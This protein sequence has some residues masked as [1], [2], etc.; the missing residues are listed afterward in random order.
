MLK[1]RDY[2]EEAIFHMINSPNERMVVCL[3]TGAGKTVVFSTYAA[4]MVASGQ[5]V[6][7][8]VNRRE[9]LTQTQNALKKMGI[10]AG[11]ISSK[12]KNFPLSKCYVMMVETIARRKAHLEA[13]KQRCSVLIVDECHIG[14]F[15]KILDGFQ[16]VIGFSATPMVTQ[17]KTPL[18]ADYHN[19]Y[20]PVQVSD[21]IKAG[22]LTNANTYAPKN[23]VSSKN[24]KVKRST[25][26]FD[27]RQMGDLLSQ[28]KYLHYAVS[29]AKKYAENKRSIVYNANIEH[30]LAVTHAMKSAGLNAYHVD[31]TTPDYERKQILMNL[32]EQPDAIVNNVGILTFGFDCPEVETIIL[33]RATT[34]LP[35]YLQMC[36]RGSRLSSKITKDSFTIVDLCGNYALHGQWQDDRDWDTLFHKKANDSEGAAPMKSCPSCDAVI[37]ARIM[38]CPHCDH[39]FEKEQAEFDAVDPELVL[40][41]QLKANVGAI[42]AKVN[43]R[44]HNVYRGLHLIKEDVFKKNQGKTLE[45]MT[46]I[47][48][49][50]LPEW[51]RENGKRNNQWHQDFCRNEMEKYYKQ[52][53]NN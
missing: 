35:L 7:I 50:L 21:L 33:N 51:C 20:T 45:Q 40:I 24:F 31:G 44:G 41:T 27:E 10:V 12:S 49:K 43:E 4:A 17:R 52:Q 5:T 46:D 37:H 29:Y 1:L 18:A 15:T 2:Q 9:L 30:S 34:S 23:S 19:V 13:L 53:T 48:L 16:K 42:M 11:V 14:N 36:G 38:V 26:E 32:F 8:A 6:A 3:P 25:G 22:H 28:E 47:Y 39:V